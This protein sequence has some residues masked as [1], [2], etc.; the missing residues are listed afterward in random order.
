MVD[1]YQDD[2]AYIHDVGFGGFALQAAPG[3]L[4][5]LRQCGMPLG[6]VV[7]L[8]CG[9]GL[10]ARELSRAGYAVFGVDFSAA[11]LKIARKRVPAAKF[12]KGS[13]LGAD[14]PRCVAITALGEIFNYRFDPANRRET[15]MPFFRRVYQALLPGGVFVFDIAEP[16]RGGGPGLHQKNF[17]GEDWALLLETE[18]DAD[19]SIL[20]RRI[21]TFRRTGRIY[22]R[23]QETHRLHLYPGTEI[24]AALRD[25]GFRAR[26]VRGYGTFRFPRGLVGIVARKP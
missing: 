5:V 2:L 24:V 21:T 25:L 20:T 8:G 15:L 13:F 1:G 10:W 17:Q 18:E 22:R 23:A 12:Q 6:L 19:Q 4:G 14:L 3:L 9:S 11:M 7:D 16:G 26:L